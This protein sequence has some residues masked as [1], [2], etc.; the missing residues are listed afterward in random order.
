MNNY[1]KKIGQSSEYRATYQ[2]ASVATAHEKNRR[3]I[4]IGNLLSTKMSSGIHLIANKGT[5]NASSW[6]VTEMG[7]AAYGKEKSRK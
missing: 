3:A 6:G 4:K 5:K 1:T 2:K 7:M